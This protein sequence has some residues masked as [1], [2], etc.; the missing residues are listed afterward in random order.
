MLVDI[1]KDLRTSAAMYSS[2][3]GIR[4]QLR[5]LRTRLA[6]DAS[7]ADVRTRADS[8]ERRFMFVADSLSQQNPGAFYEWPVKLSSKLSYLAGNVQ[9]S[10]HVP[11]NQAQDAHTFLKGQLRVAKEAYDALVQSELRAFNDVLRQRGLPPI[12]V[13]QP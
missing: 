13:T 8:L 4:G 12:L 10:D 7:N 6:S 1:A 2:I 3:E 11:T 5:T 9:S